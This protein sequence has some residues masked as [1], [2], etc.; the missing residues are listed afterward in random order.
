MLCRV[1]RYHQLSD[2]GWLEHC[3]LQKRSIAVLAA[4]IGCTPDALASALCRLRIVRKPRFVQLA[5][6]DWLFE[7]YVDQRR[8]V[9]EIAAEIGCSPAGVRT[10]RDRHGIHRQQAK[11]FDQLA[12][13][14][15]LVERYVY[16]R[17]DVATIAKEIGCAPG[18]VKSAL[19]TTRHVA[20]SQRVRSSAAVRRS[21]SQAHCDRD[22][23]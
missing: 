17:L 21:R 6:R 1:R 12:D 3:Y 7:R 11:L 23:R 22:S 10:A 18:G 2:R 19:R 5:D 4:E 8:S 15:W 16:Q 20:L 9:D 14:A 13:R